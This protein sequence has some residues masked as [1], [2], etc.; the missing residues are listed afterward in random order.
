MTYALGCDVSEWNEQV[1]FKKMVS[2]GASFTYIKA[3][4]LSADANFATNWANAKSAGILRGAFHYLDWTESELTQAALFV[5]T[6]NGDYGDLPPVC[7]FE[8]TLNAPPPAVANGKLW[9]FL[10]YVEK[11]TGRI[12]MIYSGYYYWNQYGNPNIGWLHYPFW[13]AWYES[14]DFIKTETH[15]GTGAPLP[16][17]NWTFWQYSKNGNGPQYGSQ[18]LSLDMDYYNGSV[19]DLVNLVKPSL[20][21]TRDACINDLLTKNGYKWQGE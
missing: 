19:S 11:N 8:M 5:N 4:Q 9:N 17:T 6:M 1:D 18:G 12:P 10:Q 14:A 15:G 2:G 7:D 21:P 16:W 20:L 3:S 13:L